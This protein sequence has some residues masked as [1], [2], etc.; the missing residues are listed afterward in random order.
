MY[1]PLGGNRRHLYRNLFVVWFLTGMWH[2]ASWNFILWGL[3]NGVFIALERRFLPK[4]ELHGLAAAL[5]HVYLLL[6]VNFGFVLFYFTDLS[7]L[8]GFFAAL[9][10]A[11]GRAFV[12]AEL[13]IDLLNNVFWLVLAFLLCTPL[14]VYLSR[15]FS[16]WEKSSRAGAVAV[17]TVRTVYLLA[18]LAVCTVMLVGNSFNPF[19]YFRF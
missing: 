3:Y 18:I 7:R 15:L 17:A 11:G 8:G 19:L 13:R 12:S 2:G 10:G 16:T 5:S 6:C 4:K 14:Y 1:I 9:F